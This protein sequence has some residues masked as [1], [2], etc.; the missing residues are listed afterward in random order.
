MAKIAIVGAG[1]HVFAQRLI[2]DL[3]TWPSLRDSTIT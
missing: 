2:T 3:L 1:S